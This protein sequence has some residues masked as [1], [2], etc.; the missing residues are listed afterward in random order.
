MLRQAIFRA[1]VA[2]AVVGAGLSA[3]ATAPPARSVET[4]TIAVIGDSYT[5][6][7]DMGGSGALAWPQATWGLLAKQGLTVSA[8]VQS[9]GGAGYTHIGE[10]GA[11][12]Q[13]L[14]AKAVHDDDLVVY[15]GSIN[16]MPLDPLFPGIAA[17]T[18]QLAR[19]FA[20]GAKLLVIGPLWPS[21]NPP[22]ELTDLRESLRRAAAEAGAGF[23]DPIAERWF[24]GRPDLIGQDGIHPNDAGH[25]YLGHRIA[26]LI[27]RE[28]IFGGG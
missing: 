23:A 9:E 21:G 18:F 19:T 1:G 6:G 10:Q 8:D 20:P 4:V 7:T 28:L 12:F 13:S 5:T 24:A 17:R 16:D 26:P 14:T 15:F 3:V 11:T 22:P 2:I 25:A 27:L